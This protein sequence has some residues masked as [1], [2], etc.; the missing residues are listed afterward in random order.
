MHCAERAKS[1]LSSIIGSD[2]TELK[3][4]KMYR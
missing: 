2:R 1:P 3:A 4:K